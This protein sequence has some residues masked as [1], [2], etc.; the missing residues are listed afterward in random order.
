[1]DRRA[2]LLIAGLA[3]AA[4]GGSPP[5]PVF[6]PP[7][8]PPQGAPSF[9]AV[10]DAPT[11]HV[12]GY[13]E[14]QTPVPCDVPEGTLWAS[15]NR[16]GNA[17]LDCADPNPNACY[18]VAGGV[19]TT[20]GDDLGFPLTTVQ[21]F[22]PA[23]TV[24]VQMRTAARCATPG[25]WA[26]IVIYDGEDDYAG[27]YW[28]D[29]PKAGRLEVHAYR[30]RVEVPVSAELWAEGSVHVFD[31]TWRPDGSITY[32]VDGVT[33][34]TETAASPLGPDSTILAHSPH[35]SIFSGGMS[36]SVYSIAVYEE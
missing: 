19:L 32:A 16:P 13:C 27:E 14:Q 31:L 25:C 3:L 1:M 30:T 28:R 29:S 8:P 7:L 34:F 12:A 36:L 2:L 11:M 35:V 23:K 10:F 4:C 33:R 20:R 15:F 22:D 9:V 21:T 26:G 17:G 24:H 18:A 5:A 6:G